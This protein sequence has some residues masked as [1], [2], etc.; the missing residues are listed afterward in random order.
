MP[1]FIN[2]TVVLTAFLT[3]PTL[4]TSA[5]PSA[6]APAPAPAPDV[7]V[8]VQDIPDWPRGSVIT[9]DLQPQSIRIDNTDI[10][11]EDFGGLYAWS[12]PVEHPLG[13][14]HVQYQFPD[15]SSTTWTMNVLPEIEPPY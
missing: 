5:N 12:V 7:V 11:F 2:K 3:L 8:P 14:A 10:A 15:G 9:L 4:L 13:I 6:P 1:A